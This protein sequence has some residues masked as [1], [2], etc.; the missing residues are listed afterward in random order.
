M[1]SDDSS[2]NPFIRFKNHVDG[3]IHRAFQT[4]FG[5]S[6]IMDRHENNEPTD[7]PPSGHPSQGKVSE[8]PPGSD[9]KGRVSTDE[10]LS[11]ANSSPY[12]P[13]NLQHLPQPHPRDAT[14]AYPDCFTFR[15]AFEDLLAVNSGR[16]LS[17]LQGLVLE[18]QFEHLRHFPW[19]VPVDAW[20]VDLGRRGLWDAYFP[21]SSSARREF[22]YAHHGFPRRVWQADNTTSHQLPAS[23]RRGALDSP[24]PHSGSLWGGWHLPWSESK[25]READLE[26][27]L[28]A[29][30]K[31]GFGPDSPVTTPLP[32]KTPDTQASSTENTRSPDSEGTP[33]TRVIETPGGGKIFE[34]IQ[35]RIHNG[36]NET[37]TTTKQLDA[38]GNVIARSESTRVWSSWTTSRGGEGS[39]SNSGENGNNVQGSSKST[40]WFWK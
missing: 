24:S 12:S 39:E 26:D 34:T 17:D 7:S 13:L 28:Y 11:W 8:T 10:V 36:K 14:H 2:G 4:V 35:Q 40:G 33:T 21:L 5:S 31:S 29:A 3:N 15:D 20:A 16:P 6:T 32:Q 1:P 22:F 38:H 25:G 18:R 19:G 30:L 9:D 27:D 37:T 23:S